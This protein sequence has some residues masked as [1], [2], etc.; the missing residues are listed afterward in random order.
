M[1][2]IA[3]ALERR[4]KMIRL[5]SLLL[6]PLIF[7]VSAAGLFLPG[8]YERESAAWYIQAVTQDGFDLVVLAP[9]LIA[10]ALLSKTGRAGE[11]LWGGVIFYCSYTFVIYGFAVHFNA[12]FPLYCLCLGISVF[13]FLDF[14]SSVRMDPVIKV[15]GSRR[16]S[17]IAG[18]YL[19]TI[20]VAFYLLWL[21][22]I[23]PYALSNSTPG[24]LADLGLPTNPVHVLDLSVCLPGL[25]IIALL[26]VRGNPTGLSLLPAAFVF[27]ILMNMTI[28]SI[29]VVT[30][31]NGEEG[32]PVLPVAMLIL[33][34]INILLLAW[35]MKDSSGLHK[36]P[37]K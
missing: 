35:F 31:M 5:F 25:F 24:N 37:T 4:H 15:A 10:T 12:L 11:L 34:F 17:L 6:A 21:S 18:Y 23:L 28:A 16:A 8:I 36:T 2:T 27:C 19:M 20:S 26:A 33:T 13:A 3:N 9:A 22:M 14:L 32:T 30:R 7:F 29:D 1:A